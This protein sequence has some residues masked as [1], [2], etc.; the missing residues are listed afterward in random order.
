MNA[1]LLGQ[2]QQVFDLDGFMGDRTLGRRKGSQVTQ[3]DG[4][5]CRYDNV[6]DDDAK[7][8]DADDIENDQINSILDFVTSL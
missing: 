4:E 2:I 8:E 3:E 5:L 1:Q 6:D 7:S